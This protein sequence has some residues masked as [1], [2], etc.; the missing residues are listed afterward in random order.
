M[1][2]KL[3]PLEKKLLAA[4]KKAKRQLKHVITCDG[5]LNDQQD[6]LELIEEDIEEAISE[7]EE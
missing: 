7:A 5:S 3:T 2:K 1:K 4:L 6:T